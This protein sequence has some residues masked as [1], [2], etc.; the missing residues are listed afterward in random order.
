MVVASPKGEPQTPIGFTEDPPGL[1]WVSG[2]VLTCFITPF[3]L[4][5]PYRDWRATPFTSFAMSGYM[6]AFGPPEGPPLVMPGQQFYDEAGMWAAF[7]VQATLRAARARWAHPIDLSVHEVGLFNK[8]GSEQYS[9]AGQIKTRATNFGPPPGGIWE[10]RD[11]QVDIGAHSDRQWETFVDLLGSPEVLSDP[12]YRDRVMRIQLFDLLT[13]VITSHMAT[14]S[15][16]EFVS[17]GQAAGLPCAADAHTGPIHRGPPAGSA[18]ATSSRLSVPVR[19]RCPFRAGPFARSPPSFPTGDRRPALGS[20]M[21]RSISE[22]LAIRSKSSRRGGPMAS[23]EPGRRGLLRGVRVLSFGSFVAGNICTLMLAELGAD[24]VKVESRAHPEALRAD[25]APGQTQ[26]VE[27]SGVRTTALF[28]GMTRGLRSVCIDMTSDGGRRTFRRLAGRVDV[29][30]ENLGPG[31]MEAWGCSYGDLRAD[32]PRLVMLSISGYGRSGPLAGFRAYASNINNFLGLTSAWALDGIDFDFVAGTHGACA[33]V[34]ALREVDQG[35]DGVFIDMAQTET[36]AAIMPNLY[37]DY[38]ANGREWAVGPNQVP[39]SLFSS[40]VACRGS[41][42]WVA[43]ELED[44]RDWDVMCSFLELPDLRLDPSIPATDVPLRAFRELP[45]EAVAEWAATVTPFQAAHRLQRIGLAAGP[46]QNGEDL[47]RDAQ[48]RSRGAFVDVVHPD[49]GELEYPDAPLSDPPPRG[50]RASGPWLG[51]NTGEVLR[52]VARLQRIGGTGPPG[53]CSGVVAGAV[54]DPPVFRE[55]ASRRTNAA[56]T[57]INVGRV[58]IVTGAGRGIGRGHALELARRAG[59]GRRT[60][61]V[62]T[63]TA[64]VGPRRH[65]R[66]RLSRLFRAG[67][68]KAVANRD[69]VSDWHGVDRLVQ[70]AVE[71]FG[72][73]DVVVNNAGILRDRM[74]AN[75]SIE[76]WDAVIRVHLGGTFAMMRQAAEYWRHRSKAGQRVDARIIN[77]TSASGLFGNPGQVNYRGGQ[78]GH[79]SSDHHRRRRTRPLRGHGQRDQSRGSHSHDR[80]SDAR[81]VPAGRSRHVRRVGP[82]EYRSAGR[83]VGE[84]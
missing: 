53:Q 39:G 38:L 47:W 73:L 67:G 50:P 3:G 5:G 79:R 78:G 33:V 46:V 25:D 6:H 61:W 28:A 10:C 24:V 2:S 80:T 54:S 76:E 34:A 7:L 31:T 12:I 70:T 63:S 65:P 27:P 84:S 59:N 8:L 83:V 41:D 37:L 21:K 15:A 55:H 74:L 30:I 20:P 40:V 17:A 68:G 35:A 64:A 71:E 52:G 56:V 13:D 82:W 16:R 72:L 77:T 23:S 51:A 22:T 14:R 26:V 18:R 58:A 11:G 44:E 45:H 60:M 66:S 62:V 69:D 36:G 9:V 48:L 42:A 29:V 4:T 81:V 57:G 32:N 43:I 75:M 1:T 49:L 19:G